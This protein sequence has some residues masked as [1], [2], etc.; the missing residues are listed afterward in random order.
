MK[1]RPGEKVKGER[2][3]GFAPYLREC[4]SA[5]SLMAYPVAF[6]AGLLIS[7]TPCVYPMI[8][9]QL[10]FIGE[11]TASAQTGGVRASWQSFILSVLFVTSMA[12]VYAAL[13]AFASLTSSLFGI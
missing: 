2:M 13:G 4:L 11:Q 1:R 10:S 6:F 12:I 7:F 9:I 3:S 5:G 8:P